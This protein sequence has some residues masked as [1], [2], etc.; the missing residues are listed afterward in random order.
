MVMLVGFVFVSVVCVLLS[1]CVVVVYD[2]LRP[3]AKRGNMTIN[4]FTKTN[5]YG[6]ERKKILFSDVKVGWL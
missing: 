4:Q 6:Q 1:I 3:Y 5:E 2:R